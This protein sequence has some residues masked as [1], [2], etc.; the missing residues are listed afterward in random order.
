MKHKA[1][2]FIAVLL[3]LCLMMSLGVGALADG[4]NESEIS[5]GNTH[6]GNTTGGED[7]G[8]G[9]DP[10][11]PATP[12]GGDENRMKANLTRMVAAANTV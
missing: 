4:G 11:A 6:G 8:G 3:A 12:K 10:G 1:K 7:L 9:D 2:S 5:D